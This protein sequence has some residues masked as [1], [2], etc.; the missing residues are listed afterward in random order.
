VEKALSML[1]KDDALRTFETFRSDQGDPA[2]WTIED[3][4]QV[5]RLVIKDVA[6]PSRQCVISSPGVDWIIIDTD[7]G[8]TYGIFDE[9]MDDA[10]VLKS[11][12]LFVEISD[13]YFRGDWE[14]VTAGRLLRRSTLKVNL[15]DGALTMQR[16]L[17]DDVRHMLSGR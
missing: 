5:A 3:D 8:F 15:P 16:T 13:A 6:N 4:G 11:L 2:T 14:L 1:G 9:E 7:S 12:H 10:D 17:L